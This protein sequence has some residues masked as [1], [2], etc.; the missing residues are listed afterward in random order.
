MSEKGA[1]LP[2]EL[3]WAGDLTPRVTT[4]GSTAGTPIWCRIAPEE[5][6]RRVNFTTVA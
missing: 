3:T 4:G 2:P 5:H 1:R 6:K